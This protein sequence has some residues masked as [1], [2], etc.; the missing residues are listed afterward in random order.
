[1]LDS[2]NV[3]AS[4]LMGHQQALRVIA[5]NTSNMNTPGFKSSTLGFADLF[6]ASSPG[7]NGNTVRLGHGLDATGTQLNFSQGEMRQTGGE[8]DLALEGEGMFTLRN[9][10]G[11]MRYS[12]A[13]S[14]Q[15]D[16]NGVFVNRTDG[17]KVLGMD[18]SGG[19]REITLDGMRLSAGKATATVRFNGNLSSTMPEQTVGSIKVFDAMGQEH[20]LS[21]KLTNTNSTAAGSWHAE[22]MEGSTSLGT[23]EIVFVDGKPTVE[24]AKPGFSYTPAGGAAQQLVLDLS[25]DVTSFASG[26]LSTLAMGSQDGYAPGNLTKVSFDATGTLVATYANGQTARGPRLALG[27]F[28]TPDAVEDLGGNLFGE[29][30][31]IA[32]LHGVAGEGGFASLR[33]GMLEMSNVDLSREFTELV[34]MQ[35]GYQAA[36]Q[37]ISTANDMLQELF[38]MKHK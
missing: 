18:A 27:R 35:R 32:W 24:T 28:T 8:F 14:F 22:L 36:S 1:M 33:A 7:S 2:I 3:G 29:A 34:V 5:N 19:L 23:A 6:Y 20:T 26:S 4:G 38:G 15:F 31:G 17:S 9:A 12:R 30:R 21:L 16:A 13:G 11:E 37:V 10:Q 25:S